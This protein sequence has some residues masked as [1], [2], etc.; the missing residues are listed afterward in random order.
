M[1]EELNKEKNDRINFEQKYKN[2]IKEYK[3]KINYLTKD[4]NRLKNLIQNYKNR[5]IINTNRN[6]Y[7]INNLKSMYNHNSFRNPIHTKNSFL[8][9]DNYVNKTML[10]DYDT[11]N[12][13][14]G[15]ETLINNNICI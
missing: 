5:N 10:Y 2:K 14:N 12:A 9:V 8:N 11:N 13:L 3:N 6:N 7:T 4:N 1:E 15:D